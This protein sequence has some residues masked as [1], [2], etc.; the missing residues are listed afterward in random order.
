MIE[1]AGILIIDDDNNERKTLSDILSAKGYETF[2][3]GEGR[4]GIE[5]AACHDINVAL[6]D[7]K[8]PDLPGLDVLAEIKRCS[9]S[10]EAI[11]LTGHA[12]LDAAIEAT[13]RG[14]F[15]FLRKPYE[16]EQLLLHIRRAVE[17]R[18]S[19]ERMAWLASFPR[20]NPNP[21]AETSFSGEIT[22]LT[23][24]A[25]RLFPDLPAAGLAHPLMAGLAELRKGEKEQMEREVKIGDCTY[26]QYLSCI[27]ERDCIRIY[28]FDIT[29]L[30]RTEEALQ[31]QLDEV[32]RLNRL[33]V[34]RELKMEE[35]RKKIKGMESQLA[36]LE[37]KGVR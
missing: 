31:R 19:E 30:K 22:F 16:I 14:A 20:L 28:A 3:A 29:R 36:V 32:V 33:M 24:A 1:K 26:A 37:A 27:N 35:M 8:L 7:L 11:V 9:P 13:N 2:T 17:K 6:I 18:T 21:I 5:A 12:T 15:S 25:E 10:V 4:E 23:P 34:G